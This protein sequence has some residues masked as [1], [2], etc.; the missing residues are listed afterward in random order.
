M[1]ASAPVF[2]P[3]AKQLA[4]IVPI[5]YLI[6]A[7]VFASVQV[8]LARLNPQT[9]TALAFVALFGVLALLLGWFSFVRNAKVSVATDGDVTVVDWLGRLRFRAPRARVRLDLVSVRDLGQKRDVAILTVNDGTAAVPLWREIWGDDVIRA[10]VHLLGEGAATSVFRQLSKRAFR[11]RYPH[12]HSENLAA[13]G[14]VVV[15]V[16]AVA[17]VVSRS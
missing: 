2:R 11:E 5:R 15:C 14:V 4:Q 13:I 6:P 12:L 7:L 16:L 3:R 8:Y 1:M 17:I 10:L 9:A